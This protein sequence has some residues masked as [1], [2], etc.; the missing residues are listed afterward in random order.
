MRKKFEDSQVVSRQC[1][2]WTEVT[3]W[4]DEFPSLETSIDYDSGFAAK[5]W[6][7][8]GLKSSAYELQPSIER[9]ARD[10]TMEWAALEELVLS[11]YKAR[12]RMHLSA[13]LIPSDEVSWLAQM[14]HYAIPT[15]L[16][17]FTY[18]PFVALYFAVA[19]GHQES[20]RTHLRLWAVDAEAVNNRFK[21]VARMAA[22]AAK[23]EG[24]ETFV[25]ANLDPDYFSTD[26]D[27][28]AADIQELH[29]L[30]NSSLTANE[31]R[32]GVLN[33]SGCVCAALP[34]AFNPRLASQQGL[35]LLNC[36]ENISFSA[37]LAKMMEGSDGWCKVIDIPVGLI[38]EIEGR[39]FQ[40]NVHHQSLF[41][42]MEG[43]AGLIRQK[44]RLHWK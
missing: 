20:G 14:Q 33:R 28:V 12:A 44:L 13:P 35:F 15:R 32:R 3:K 40:M 1:S 36:A 34:P 17:D 19:D 18:S 31:K 5:A 30:M 16:L 27:S 11:E 43:L 7:F 24:G 41:P 37:S 29:E 9:E 2:N 23:K 10:K 6:V 26:R 21:F 42:D 25:V 4:F 38:P 8:R 22:R 39:L